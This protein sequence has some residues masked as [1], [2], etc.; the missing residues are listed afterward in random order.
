MPDTPS[1]TLPETPAATPRADLPDDAIPTTCTNCEGE[2]AV[3]RLSPTSVLW[4]CKRCPMRGQ[5]TRG[6]TDMRRHLTVL[7]N[8]GGVNKP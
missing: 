5:M 3:A 4:F 7:P 8:T 1:P 6:S 2:L